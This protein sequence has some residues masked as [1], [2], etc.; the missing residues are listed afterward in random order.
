MGSIVVSVGNWYVLKRHLQTEADAAALAGAAMANGCPGDAAAK[1]A[2]ANRMKAEALKYAGDKSQANQF[3]YQPED[4][5]DVHVVF[6]STRY[7]DPGDLNDGSTLD[8]TS[9]T[10]ATRSSSR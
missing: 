10:R 3:N 7:W 1:I 6:N 4:V 2:T 5:S 9:G 8:W